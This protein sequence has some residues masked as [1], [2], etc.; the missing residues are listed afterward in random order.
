MKTRGNKTILSAICLAG[1]LLAV[2]AKAN[3]I[4]DLNSGNAAL[5]GYS[6]P[7]GS[8]NVNLTDSTH[9]TITFT[10]AS[11]YVF[12]GTGTAG[13][14]VNAA[15]WSISSITASGIGPVSDDGTKNEDGWGSFNQTLKS[16]DG[17]THASASVSFV[18]TDIGGSWATSA[19]V[20]TNPNG[21]YVAAHIFV[22]GVG[23]ALS[24]GFASG[25]SG[26]P[27]GGSTQVPDGGTTVALL[28]FAIAGIG[29][30]RRK[31][32]RN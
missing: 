23:D 27:G 8:V 22:I 26:H 29:L 31:L 30:A 2:A 5:T 6:A 17:F 3:T 9:A 7:F 12:G 21:Y 15:N 13:V 25:N 32:S 18:L 20:L 24:T 4:Y 28:G 14:N 16:F 11:G 10:A 19:D 1:V